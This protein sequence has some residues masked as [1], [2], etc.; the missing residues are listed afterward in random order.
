MKAED[1]ALTIP[2]ECQ[3]L[4]TLSESTWTLR[5]HVQ[6][7]VRIE[8]SGLLPPDS[9]VFIVS[10]EGRKNAIQMLN[11]FERFKLI[12]NSVAEVKMRE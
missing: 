5:S 2:C 1:L 12:F 3:L 9:R 6:H 7:R 4:A 10:N 11:W 8:F